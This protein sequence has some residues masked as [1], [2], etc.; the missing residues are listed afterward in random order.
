MDIISSIILALLPIIGLGCMYLSEM[1]AQKFPASTMALL[2]QIG[3]YA[4]HSVEQSF[5]NAPSAQKKLLAREF[6]IRIIEEMG[7]TPPSNALTD[8]AIESF[9]LTMNH[10][11]QLAGA[12]EDPNPLARDA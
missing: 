1:L 10:V 11:T 5:V 9:V 7:G 8:A 3:P 6:I 2:E 4:V 12:K